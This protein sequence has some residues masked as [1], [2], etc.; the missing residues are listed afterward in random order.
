[1]R[2]SADMTNRSF[3]IVWSVRLNVGDVKDTGKR[4]RTSRMSS[5]ASNRS[6]C[7]RKRTAM[8]VKNKI[9]EPL[10]KARLAATKERVPQGT[11]PRMNY[12]ETESVFATIEE[13]EGLLRC[14][15]DSEDHHYYGFRCGKCDVCRWRERWERQNG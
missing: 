11:M 15:T 7:V 13:M 5:A 8:G 4:E 10:T 1:M 2:D 6:H 9:V 3:Q 12:E 14:P